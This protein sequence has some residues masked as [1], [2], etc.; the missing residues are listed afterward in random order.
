MPSTVP[1]AAK[2]SWCVAPDVTA[3]M[4][5][6]AMAKQAAAVI[7]LSVFMAFKVILIPTRSEVRA[8]ICL[9]LRCQIIKN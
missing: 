5:Q 3:A 4:A 7:E 1:I 6:A 2:A 8:G 9:T